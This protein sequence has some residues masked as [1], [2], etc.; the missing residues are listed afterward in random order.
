MA[1]ASPQPN[2][3]TMSENLKSF[4]NGIELCANLPAVTGAEAIVTA[5]AN[6]NR[7]TREGFEQTKR[8]MREGFELVNN[9]F[10]E[11]ERKMNALYV[12]FVRSVQIKLLTTTNLVRPTQSLVSS[13]PAPYML[14]ANSNPSSLQTVTLS[15]TS[16]QHQN[17][18]IVCLV[19]LS[20]SN[21]IIAHN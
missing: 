9:R 5:I 15:P 6:L 12:E 1:L 3:I 16:Q 10:T 20:Y 7:E 19:W 4:A 17:D 8:E 18:S 21:A 13:I 14:R 11:L 2:F